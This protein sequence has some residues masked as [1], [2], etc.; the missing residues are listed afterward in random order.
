MKRFHTG[1]V[2]F[3]RF[4]AGY[5]LLSVFF[6]FLTGIKEAEEAEESEQ[7]EEIRVAPKACE[8]E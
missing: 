8:A 2:C 1:E 4:R 7:A 6:P 5:F 3:V